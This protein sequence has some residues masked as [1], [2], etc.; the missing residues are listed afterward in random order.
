MTGKEGAFFVMKDQ[1]AGDC[2]ARRRWLRNE[3]FL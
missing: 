1:A 2:P 3:R